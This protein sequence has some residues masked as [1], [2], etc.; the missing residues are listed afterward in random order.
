MKC[1]ERG[2]I[3]SS[4]S[5]SPSEQCDATLRR[6]LAHEIALADLDP[7]TAENIVCRRRMEIEVRHCE[8]IEIGLGVEVAR[9]AALRD[10]DLR[11]F[12]TVELIGLQAFQEID[13]LVDPRFHLRVAVVDGG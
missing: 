6:H 7:E 3:A 11:V 13:G 8:V 12:P 4:A 9:L 2:G 5:P 10:R 1:L